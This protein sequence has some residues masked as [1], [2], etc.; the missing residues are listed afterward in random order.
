[1]GTRVK[2]TVITDLAK[3]TF[4]DIQNTEYCAEELVKALELS[5]SLHIFNQMEIEDDSHGDS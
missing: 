5:Y 2:A 3:W 1:M 4:M